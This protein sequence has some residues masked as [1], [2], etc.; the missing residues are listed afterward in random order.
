MIPV[1]DASGNRIFLKDRN[2]N[3]VAA[4]DVHESDDLMMITSNGMMVTASTSCSAPTAAN[5]PKRPQ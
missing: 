4:R 3:V 5:R 1:T 2:G